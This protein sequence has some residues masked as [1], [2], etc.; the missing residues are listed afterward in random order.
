MSEQKKDAGIPSQ[1][2][3]WV[4]NLSKTWLMKLLAKGLARIGLSLS[5]PIGWIASFLVEKVLKKIGKV[6]KRAYI[7]F[8]EQKETEKEVKEYK[9]E[10]N[11]PDAT[12]EEISNEGSKFLS[13]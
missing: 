3:A 6:L 9:K 2:K 10:I 11:A 1:F 4:F 7:F 5:G 12:K 13:S 8:A